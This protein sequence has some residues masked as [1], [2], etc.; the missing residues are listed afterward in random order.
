MHKQLAAQL[1][2]FV[3]QGAAAGEKSVHAENLPA[4]LRAASASKQ[5]G[6]SAR[7]ID[8]ARFVRPERREPVSKR[9]V[10]DEDN[11]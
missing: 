5:P 10:G 9:P 1:H 2:S 3:V 7:T 6:H 4:T 8:A 11:M